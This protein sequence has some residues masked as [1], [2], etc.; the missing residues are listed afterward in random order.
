MLVFISYS[1]LAVSTRVGCVSV[2]K[3][4]LPCSKYQGML[5]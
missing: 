1:Y 5:C 2:Y 3:L 4:Q